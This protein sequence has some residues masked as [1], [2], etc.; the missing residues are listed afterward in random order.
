MNYTCNISNGPSFS[1]LFI[2]AANEFVEIFVFLLLLTLVAQEELLID[3]V[4]TG[5]ETIIL[6]NAQI[7]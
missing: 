5:H 6:N 7:A 1:S 4:P 3:V 2:Y